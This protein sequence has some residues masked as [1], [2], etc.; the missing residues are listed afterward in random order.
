LFLSEKIIWMEIERRLRE[1]RYSN[2]PKVES[3][4]RGGHKA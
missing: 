3:S 1:R 2:R 4:S